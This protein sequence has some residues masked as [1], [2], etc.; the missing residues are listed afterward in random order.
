MSVLRRSDGR[1]ERPE[2]EVCRIVMID[3]RGAGRQDSRAL[4]PLQE[5][6]VPPE[7]PTYWF[8]AKSFGWGWGAPV[9]WQ[10]WAVLAA[11]AILVAV[12]AV[13]FPP[14]DS[15]GAYLTYTVSLG[16]LLVAICWWKGER[17]SWRSGKGERR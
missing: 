2:A 8:P 6:P 9:T 17:P 11:F 7:R 5:P 16:L 10:G 4:D 14:A 13:I 3:D 12:G 1:A 15:F